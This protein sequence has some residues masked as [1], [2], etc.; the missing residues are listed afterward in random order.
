MS[1]RSV[2]GT[3]AEPTVQFEELEIEGEIY[4]LVYDFDAIAKAEKLVGCNLLAGMAGIIIEEGYYS[5]S[6]VLGLFYASLQRAH[7]KMTM[8]DVAVLC[9]IDRIPDIVDAIRGAYNKSMPD[10]KKTAGGEG[11]PGPN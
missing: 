3:V 8:R 6:Q 9:R 2:A 4:N 1:K 11:Q 7:P 10:V 5:A